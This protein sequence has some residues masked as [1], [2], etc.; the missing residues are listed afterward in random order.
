MSSIRI[1]LENVRAIRLLGSFLMIGGALMLVGAYLAFN[2]TVDQ[3]M[4]PLSRQI[5]SLQLQMGRLRG[6]VAA[7]GRTREA[8]ISPRERLE[9]LYRIEQDYRSTYRG[10][11]ETIDRMRD[12]GTLR[13]VFA[14]EDIAT[15]RLLALREWL[16][17]EDRDESPILSPHPRIDQKLA[18][19]APHLTLYFD[20]LRVDRLDPAWVRADVNAC[21][22]TK[23]VLLPDLP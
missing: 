4:Q 6:L 20:C 22:T 11:V 5:V 16:V 21:I 8:T 1:L 3:T 15:L 2:E 12:S 18:A 14:P 10:M 7:A 13:N 23:Q 19:L 9:T 17:L